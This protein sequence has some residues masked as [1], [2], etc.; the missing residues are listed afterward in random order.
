MFFRPLLH[1][2]LSIEFILE[3]V[4]DCQEL[5]VEDPGADKTAEVKSK[6][7]R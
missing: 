1:S 4:M 2:L 6:T 3:S 7:H 5:Q